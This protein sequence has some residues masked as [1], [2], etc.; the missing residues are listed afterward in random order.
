M[1]EPELP[2]TR[3]RRLMTNSA[4]V[5][6]SQILVRVL[7]VVALVMVANRVEAKTY[8]LYN[9]ALI[10]AG[11]WSVLAQFGL[12]VPLLRAMAREPER[13][14]DILAQVLLLRLGFGLLTLLAA[15][16]YGLLEFHGGRERGIYGLLLLASVTS[17]LS[18]TYEEALQSRDSF[19]RPALV[20]L[21]NGLVVNV[22]MIVGALLGRP[23]AWAV[24]SQLAAALVSS[25]L[26][27]RYCAREFSARPFR[28]HWDGP[29]ARELVQLAAGAAV[30]MLIG[31]WYGRADLLMARAF[32]SPTAVGQYSVPLR[33]LDM[34]LA[35]TMALAVTAQPLLSR[36]AAAGDGSHYRQ[37]ATLLRVGSVIF[38][39]T[40]I[41]V[42]DLSYY[43]LKV[44][45]PE[46]QQGYEALGVLFWV[47]LWTYYGAI[48]HH[49][50]F[51]AN[52]GWSVAAC[53]LCGLLVSLAVGCY[54]VP[55]WGIS[56]AAAARLAGE[57]AVCGASV[58][59]LRGLT[60]MGWTTIVL[61]PAG[62][63]LAMAAVWT[64]WPKGPWYW[65]SP[66]SL[67]VYAVLAF[68]VQPLSREEWLAIRA[69]LGRRSVVS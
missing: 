24:G 31:V 65:R 58:I 40:C 29:L 13:E 2:S 69:A 47:T 15:G 3:T 60:R 18:P 51:L 17:S 37:A 63:G 56:G 28:L 11:N 20:A 64:L 45:R 44:F 34:A 43:L 12:R 23:I 39:P 27:A 25:A 19:G 61:K 22:G 7:S 1:P 68:L 67:A 46:Y 16:A 35:A 55:R 62:M 52:R 21:A 26:L 14:R 53:L 6:A 54:A 49:L 57:M 36:S 4:K 59:A 8:G 5:L 42:G 33:A 10:L 9:S 66:A 50:L 38:V 41:I 32:L 48:I 30:T